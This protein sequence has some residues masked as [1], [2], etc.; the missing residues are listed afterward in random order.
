MATGMLLKEKRTP[1]YHG[2]VPLLGVPSVAGLKDSR[3]H[4]ASEELLQLLQKKPLYPLTNTVYEPDG[5]SSNVRLVF[6]LF[7]TFSMVVSTDLSPPVVVYF[8]M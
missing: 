8:R 3:R 4:I 1:R 5:W 7:C 2:V 6:V